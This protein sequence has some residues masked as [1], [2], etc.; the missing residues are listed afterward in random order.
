MRHALDTPP[1]PSGCPR[2]TSDE[3]AEITRLACTFRDRENEEA[4]D[5]P[6]LL[7]ADNRGRSVRFASTAQ[8]ETG[9]AET[10]Q[11]ERAGFGDGPQFPRTI[12]LD[13]TTSQT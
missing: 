13:L 3:S 10:E 11:R 7:D 8:A 5:R 9:E 1:R 4:P 6:G 12:V 2:I